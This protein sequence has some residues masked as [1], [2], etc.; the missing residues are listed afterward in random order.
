[1]QKKI[2]KC[3]AC[4]KTWSSHH[5]AKNQQYCSNQCYK[6]YKYNT[7][8]SDWL[9]GKESGLLNC[10]K[11]L[12]PTR[13]PL[14]PL[15]I[16]KYLL[17]QCNYKCIQCGWGEINPYTKKTALQLDHIDGDRTNN[18]PENLRILCPNCHSL[19]PNW[20]GC[21]RKIFDN[22][23]LRKEINGSG[24]KNQTSD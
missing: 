13:R 9:N 19:T 16:R 8:I 17:E 11:R 22:G 12:K 7:F 18:R 14:Y 10:G 4:P 23:K 24:G 5:H 2:N 20:M 3:I 15:S 21:N 6:T 1:M